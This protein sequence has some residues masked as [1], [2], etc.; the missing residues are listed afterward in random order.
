MRHVSETPWPKLHL[1]YWFTPTLAQFNS[2][3]K[4]FISQSLRLKIRRA[5]FF[6]TCKTNLLCQA[7]QN[8]EARGR[9]GYQKWDDRI[10]HHLCTLPGPSINYVFSKS[11][12]WWVLKRKLFGQEST[13]HQGK[14]IKKILRVMTVCEKVPKLYFQSHFG[15]QKLIE[16]FQKKKLSKNINLGDHYFF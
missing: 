12:R 16:F 1:I 3:G 6:C 2:V 4:H 14:I 5:D 13:W 11:A 15:C 8:P 10:R 9:G 7:C